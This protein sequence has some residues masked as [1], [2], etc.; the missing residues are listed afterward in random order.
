MDS[1]PEIKISFQQLRSTVTDPSAEWQRLLGVTGDFAI[2]IGGRLFYKEE[3]FPVVEFAHQA[4][5]WLENPSV[6]FCYNSMESEVEPLI[7]CKEVDDAALAIY[8]PH[9]AENF[10]STVRKEAIIEELKSFVG[11]LRDRV[12]SELGLDLK[13]VL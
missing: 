5:R 1:I 9:Q 8:S 6:K 11:E 13:Q 12:R 10:N 4:Q 3:D 7:E 2:D